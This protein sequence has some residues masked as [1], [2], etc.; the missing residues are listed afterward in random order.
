MEPPP[1][2][3]RI[4][5]AVRALLQAAGQVEVAIAERLGLGL[6]DLQAM[7]HLL[8]NPA[9]AGPAELSRRLGITSASTTALLDRLQ[10]AG[11]LERERHGSDRRRV[12]LHPTRRSQQRIREQ[13]A[14][15]VEAT[16]R[17][18]GELKPDERRAVERF[19]E[20][21]T[22]AMH[23]FARANRERTTAR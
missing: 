11:H 17:I 22:A 12:L 20:Q 10:R 3:E 4:A 6:R 13:L 8:S 1:E 16:V 2:P 18:A 14:P 21:V 15:L 5:V 19:L 9:P 23:E 7:D